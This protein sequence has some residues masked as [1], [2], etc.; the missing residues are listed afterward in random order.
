MGNAQEQTAI[1]IEHF[2]K[3]IHEWVL[4]LSQTDKDT[5]GRVALLERRLAKLEFDSHL[6]V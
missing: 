6:R 5:A 2:K 3:A 1:E 4:Y